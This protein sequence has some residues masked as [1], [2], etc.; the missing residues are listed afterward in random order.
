[1]LNRQAASGS[2]LNETVPQ[3]GVAMSSLGINGL[4]QGLSQLFGGFS[5]TGPASSA[6]GTS[7]TSAASSATSDGTASSATQSGALRVGGHHRH[8]HGFGKQFE[9]IQ[10]AVTS[11]LQSAQ[12]SGGASDPNKVIEDAIAKIF[13]QAGSAPSASGATTAAQDSAANDPDG[14]ADVDAPGQ[15]DTDNNSSPQAFFK[16]LASLGVSPQ[17]F[18]NDFLAAVKDAQQSGNVDVG[19]ALK[20]LPKGLTLDAIG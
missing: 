6:S 5:N 12:S 17:Q 13:K 18:R 10:D 11:A 16:S 15:A 1:M 9:Q 7:S 14:A 8:G 19:A 4:G 2:L 3:N 20:S